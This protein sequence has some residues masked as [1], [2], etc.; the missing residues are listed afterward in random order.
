MT[1]NSKHA[2][3]A[4]VL[5]TAVAGVSQTHAQ[6]RDQGSQVIVYGA[7]DLGLE[8][9]KNGQ[10]SV[11]RVSSGMSTVSRIGFRGSEDLG[12]GL[13]ANFRLE[14]GLNADDGTQNNA[15]K[16][17]GRWSYVGLSGSWGAIDLGRMWSP[18]FVV[19][20]TSDPLARNRTSLGW[21]MFLAQTRRTDT[22]FTP[23]FTDNSVR[24]T[25]PRV[26]G[27]WGELMYSPGEAVD[28]ASSG[29]GLGLN[30]QYASGPLYLGYGYQ[31]TNSGTATVPVANP[32]ASVSHFFGATYRLG[33]VTL[34]GT[35]NR[36]TADATSIPDS[37]NAMVSARWAVGGPHV[38]LAQVAQRKVSGVDARA[39]GL[40]IGY[41]YLLSKRTSLYARIARVNNDGLSRIT[42]N[43]VASQAAG[44]D[45][46]FT[47][48]GI[49]HVF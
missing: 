39:R 46:S 38:L 34:Y 6:A 25:T 7:A 2:K 11:N 24:Y 27:V 40:Q 29:R 37:T 18:T 48:L 14:S 12:G 13:R 41:D 15:T 28:S 17:F 16:F 42:L 36:N 47:G 8:F 22:A 10:T 4:L 1:I 26:G 44:A 49:S 35:L 45:A 19:G 3:A 43:G 33:D 32:D 23:G 9:A 31:R 21:N 20:L 30:L 5:M